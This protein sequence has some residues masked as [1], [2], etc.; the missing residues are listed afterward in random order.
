VGETIKKTKIVQT[1][2]KSI[3]AQM[4]QALKVPSK[5]D[6]E[7]LRS[8][9]LKYSNFALKHEATFHRLANK[10]KE[11]EFINRTLDW[12]KGRSSTEE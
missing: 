3:A 6:T 8:N 9:L 10:R 2:T 11:L 12:L 7:K 5:E 1:V 4:D